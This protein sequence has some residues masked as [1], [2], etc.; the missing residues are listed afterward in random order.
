MQPLFATS[1]AWSQLP[2]LSLNPNIGLTLI[3]FI[4]L[5]SDVYAAALK[6]VESELSKGPGFKYIFIIMVA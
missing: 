5:A 3:P 2:A 4:L 1:V 6:T